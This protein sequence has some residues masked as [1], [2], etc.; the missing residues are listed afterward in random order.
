MANRSFTLAPTSYASFAGK[1]HRLL[2]PYSLQHVME[3]AQRRRV[4]KG[5]VIEFPGG[6]FS[7]IVRNLSEAGAALDVPSSLGIPDRFT[8]V[9]SANGARVHC[10]SVWRNARR[11]GVTFT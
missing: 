3:A 8:L 5:G 10:R 7:C 4:L 6:A 11:I 2:G 9:M 1:F